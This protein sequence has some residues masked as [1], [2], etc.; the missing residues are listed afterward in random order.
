MSEQLDAAVEKLTS[1]FQSL[2]LVAQGLIVNA[3][4]VA[5]A[6]AKADTDTSE[7][8]ALSV[9]AKYNPYVPPEKTLK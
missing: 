8:V 3:K 2:D 9:L 1:T 7:F 6:L 4:E 5:E